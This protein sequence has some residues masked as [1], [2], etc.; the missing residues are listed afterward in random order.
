MGDCAATQTAPSADD[1]RANDALQTTAT[2]AAFAVTSMGGRIN[3]V[4]TPEPPV[5]GAFNAIGNAATLMQPRVFEPDDNLFAEEAVM[6]E[7]GV[8]LTLPG[9]SAEPERTVQT[10]Q[11]A[12]GDPFTGVIRVRNTGTR[13]VVP[14]R[15]GSPLAAL[16]LGDDNEPPQ[17]N[18]QVGESAVAPSMR[19]RALLVPAGSG[20]TFE[21]DG[22]SGAR[23]RSVTSVRTSSAASSERDDDMDPATRAQANARRTNR[24]TAA[25]ARAESSSSTGRSTSAASTSPASGGEASEADTTASSTATN[26]EAGQATSRTQSSSTSR[27]SILDRLRAGRSSSAGAANGTTSARSSSSRNAN[28]GEAAENGDAYNPRGTFVSGSSGGEDDSYVPRGSLV[29]GGGGDD[30]DDYAPRGTFVSD[31]DGQGDDGWTPQG[32]LIRG[33]GRGDDDTSFTPSQREHC[34]RNRSLMGA[35]FGDDDLTASR[36]GWTFPG[37]INGDCPLGI[38]VM[39]VNTEGSPF[40]SMDF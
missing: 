7:E 21:N 32:T 10:T 15:K 30:G 38:G 37:L 11:V 33:G 5:I 36:P 3:D 12:Q 22:D 24:F 13:G 28:G 9:T 34:P 29:N 2:Q 18:F 25:L 26:D 4:A 17:R 35:L 39:K 40:G 20:S 14:V 31:A 8:L 1:A 19:L 6:E 27:V 23:S 16:L